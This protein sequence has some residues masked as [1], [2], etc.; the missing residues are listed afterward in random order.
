MQVRES[1]THTLIIS[2]GFD[3]QLER[4]FTISF[5]IRV[6]DGYYSY[7]MRDD[8]PF[9]ACMFGN[10]FFDTQIPM[11]LYKENNFGK[12]WV[13]IQDIKS[14]QGYTFNYSKFN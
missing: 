3:R 4:D 12:P 13:K 7:I 8:V 6:T 9:P 14:T 2:V 5:R 1:S 10:V 11:S